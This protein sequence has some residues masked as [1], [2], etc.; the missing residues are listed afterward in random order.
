V[1][2]TLRLLRG[3]THVIKSLAKRC[4]EQFQCGVMGLYLDDIQDNVSTMISNLGHMQKRLGRTHVDYLAQLNLDKL[5]QTTQ[6][7]KVLIKMMILAMILVQLIFICGLVNV[8]F[9]SAWW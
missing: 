2:N 4:N 8:S 9:L 1:S 3:K 5:V 7:R 6:I